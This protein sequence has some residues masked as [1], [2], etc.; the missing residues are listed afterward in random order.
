MKWYQKFW[1]AI[2]G[3]KFVG[4]LIGV[5]YCAIT[6]KD[7]PENLLWLLAIYMTANAVVHL[8]GA[9]GKGTLSNGEGGEK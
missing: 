3:K 8:A 5:L 6:G 4:V 9:L 7:I 1:E 2:G